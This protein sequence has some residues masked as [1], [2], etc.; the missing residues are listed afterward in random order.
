MLL[1]RKGF[2]YSSYWKAHAVSLLSQCYHAHTRCP[3]LHYNAQ[4]T[5]VDSHSPSYSQQPVFE[6]CKS[7]KDPFSTCK[8]TLTSRDW[9]TKL[10][11][12][13]N[14]AL[15]SQKPVAALGPPW[16]EQAWLSVHRPPCLL[17][18]WPANSVFLDMILNSWPDIYLQ[19]DVPVAP[20]LLTWFDHL[21]QL[22]NWLLFYGF[23]FSS[24]SQS[25]D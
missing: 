4:P 17:G 14:W 9:F 13:L 8:D 15:G 7:L 3:W 16:L 21:H 11:S 18:F 24:E 6:T 2:F 5:P 12:S 23:F 1:K 10:K 25:P 20:M 22:R 19:T